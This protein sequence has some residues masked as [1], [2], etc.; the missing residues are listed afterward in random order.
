M[1]REDIFL[2]PDSLNIEG[3]GSSEIKS[4]GIYSV[5]VYTLLLEG[6]G[7]FNP[8]E[9][10]SQ[11]NPDEI[12]WDSIRVQI[13]YPLL[14]GMKRIDPFLWNGTEQFSNPAARASPSTPV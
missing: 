12:Q 14:K 3:H 5:P 8:E 2:L 4:R 1:K 11:Y 10:L 13:S 7:V 6:K 9:T